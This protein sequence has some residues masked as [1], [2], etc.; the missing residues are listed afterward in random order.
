MLRIALFLSLF[1]AQ[2]V[3]KINITT[4]HSHFVQKVTNDQNRTLRYEGEV[5]FSKKPFGIKWLYEKPHHKEIYIDA[6]SAIIIEPELEQATFRR[7]NKKDD[8]FSL[9]ENAKKVAPGHYVA[10]YKDKKIDIFLNDGVIARIR[11]KDRLDNLNEIVFVDT[12][13]NGKI[14]EE[15]FSFRIPQGWD[16]IRE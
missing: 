9:L 5:W 15:V 3:A 10:T 2:L 14:D 8:L 11:Y 6:T 16:I 12:K 4:F 7:F 1:I 13:Q